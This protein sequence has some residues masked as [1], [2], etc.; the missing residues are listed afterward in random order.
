MEHL[1]QQSLAHLDGR[2]VDVPAAPEFTHGAGSVQ[3]G[4]G[5]LS[6]DNGD[7]ERAEYRSLDAFKLGEDKN[8]AILMARARYL[9]AW[10]NM[11]A[12][13]TRSARARRPVATPA[14]P[15]CS[16]RRRLTS[17]VE[18]RIGGSL[19]LPIYGRG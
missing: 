3:L 1:R 12:R 18:P 6:L 15:T 2:R 9:S 7:Y 19:R 11:H 13:R 8:D 17:P 5:Y 16:S 4:Y 10:S 14:G